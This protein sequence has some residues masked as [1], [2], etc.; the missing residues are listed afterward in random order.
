MLT[1]RSLPKIVKATRAHLTSSAETSVTEG[2]LL[3]IKST[4]NK[5]T[6]EK[7]EHQVV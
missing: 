4:K 6:G 2:E 1:M 5:I 7:A 3:V